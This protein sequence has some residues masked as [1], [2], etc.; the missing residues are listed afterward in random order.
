MHNFIDQRFPSQ[1]SFRTEFGPEFQTEVTTTSSGREY[2]KSLNFRERKKYYLAATIQ[3]P[4]EVR[5]LNDFFYLTKG[6]FSSF[7]FYD[8]LDNR[9][10]NETIGIGDGHTK[11]F[12]LNKTY[13]YNGQKLFNKKIVC[14]IKAT[15]K[16]FINGTI[17]TA[18]SVLDRGVI[19]FITAPQNNAAIRVSC[20]FD[21]VVRFDNDYLP[22]ILEQPDIFRVDGLRL[23]E[24]YQN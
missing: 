15:L 20:E 22:I 3:S 7:R 11:E 13:Y 8:V 21:I 23:I 24:V 10:D 1:I 14:P 16:I 5:I 6:K 12:Q 17:C 2:R 19:K 4:E 9:L 18:Y